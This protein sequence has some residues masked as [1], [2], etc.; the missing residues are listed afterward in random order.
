M[1]DLE[2]ARL[3][4]FPVERLSMIVNSVYL[5]GKSPPND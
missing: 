3:G 2:S 4:D 1:L 5:R